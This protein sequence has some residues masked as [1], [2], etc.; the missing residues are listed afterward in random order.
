MLFLF[1]RYYKVYSYYVNENLE[2]SFFELIYF[3]FFNLNGNC[4]NRGL[5][6]LEIV[7]LFWK[8]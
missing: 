3:I 4:K 1:L 5:E 8:E 6:I 7:E 2:F